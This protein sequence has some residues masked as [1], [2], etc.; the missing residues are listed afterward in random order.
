MRSELHKLHNFFALSCSTAFL[1]DCLKRPGKMSA[2]DE[3]SRQRPARTVRRKQK[4]S[5]VFPTDIDLTLAQVQTHAQSHFP[6]AFAALPTGDIPLLK[7][8][9]DPSGSSL[10]L[11]IGHIRIKNMD[12]TLC[13][14]MRQPFTVRFSYDGG[15]C[16]LPDDI[17]L[18]RLDFPFRCPLLAATG[19]LTN[20]YPELESLIGYFMV[21]QG[22]IPTFRDAGSRNRPSLSALRTACM[23]IL[24]AQEHDPRAPTIAHQNASADDA[25]GKSSPTVSRI[26]VGDDTATQDSES[27]DEGLFVPDSREMTKE[28]LLEY[29]LKEARKV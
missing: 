23:S 24:A 7:Q 4:R 15:K 14:Y 28:Q 9:I 19:H 27:S 21:K 18:F 29:D 13:A 6:D 25:P 16:P 2:S 20:V 22:V 11:K 12:Y 1:L 17:R 10:R 26:T 5:D 3:P 8:T